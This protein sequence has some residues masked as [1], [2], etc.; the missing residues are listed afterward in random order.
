MLMKSVIKFWL[1][2]ST[3]LRNRLE[4]HGPSPACVELLKEQWYKNHLQL[5]MARVPCCICS[6]SEK[7]TQNKN[8]AAEFTLNLSGLLCSEE[9]R[10]GSCSQLGCAVFT[11]TEQH[12]G[13]S[14]W[15]SGHNPGQVEGPLHSQANAECWCSL[16]IRVFFWH[17]YAG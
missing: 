1:C 9:M 6:T 5:F 4:G 11:A 2:I 14:P 3:S 12:N 7:E 8:K 13:F 16:S 17:C 10:A 15:D